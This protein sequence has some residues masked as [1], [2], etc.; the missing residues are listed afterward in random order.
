VNDTLR[1]GNV[2]IT[3]TD[4]EHEMGE[5]TARRVSAQVISARAAGEIPVLWLMAAPSAFAFYSAFVECCRADTELARVVREIDIYQFDDYPVGRGDAR[6]GVTFRALLE[7]R[8]YAPLAAVCGGLTGGHPLELTGTR[9]DRDIARD[10]GRE[11]EARCSDPGTRVIQVKGIGMDGHW[12]FHGAE[13]PLD[14]PPA[15]IEVSIGAQNVRQQRIDWPDLFRSDADVP[16][17]AYTATVSLFLEADYIIDNVPQDSKQY[18][19]LA[20]YGAG[21]VSGAVPSSALKGHR[22]AEAVVTRAAAAALLEYR[23]QTTG[24][25]TAP[26][27]TGDGRGESLPGATLDRLRALWEDPENPGNARANCRVME[28]VLKELGITGQAQTGRTP[29]PGP[30]TAP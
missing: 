20:C 8:L 13:T 9:R 4:T 22:N 28:G 1:A 6:F 24:D 18:A 5:L 12:G 29:K 10:Y 15:V 17:T 11:I 26:A 2:D 27:E 14:S 25:R 21:R 23:G 30:G 7:N 3:V 16:R 19:V